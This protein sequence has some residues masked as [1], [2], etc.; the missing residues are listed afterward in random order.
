MDDYNYYDT[1][2]YDS[3][4]AGQKG[5]DID[6]FELNV[7]FD[8]TPKT[9]ECSQFSAGVRTNQLVGMADVENLQASAVY[10]GLEPETEYIWYAQ[11]TNEKGGLA[12]SDFVRFYHA[13]E[14]GADRPH[15]SD[16]TYSTDRSHESD[17]TYSTDRPHE[18]DGTDR[19][20]GSNGT[21]STDRPHESN[22][23]YRSDTAHGS[24]GTYCS[25]RITGWQ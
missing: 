25:G 14:A 19:P 21:Y 20:H 23:T 9:L 15:G 6:I 3:Y 1:E 17:G 5:Q 11:V 18:S 22:G 7:A 10:T 2:K 16:G 4:E 13:G 8:T 12:V 24:D